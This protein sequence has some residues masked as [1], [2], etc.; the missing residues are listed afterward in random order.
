MHM[1]R[2]TKAPHAPELKI[3][4]TRRST[5]QPITAAELN[6]ALLELPSVTSPGDDKI[7]CEGLKQLGR[8][9]RRGILRLLNYIWRTGQVPATWRQGIIVP[10]L[11]P[12]EPPNS[13]AS[14][15]PV[16]LTST[17]CKL[18]ERIVARRVRD[19][20]EEKLQPQQ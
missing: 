2:P 12:N 8:V 15:R 1:G 14:F 18:M 3:P 7:H 17:L 16:T 4:S 9:S 19:C 6:V 20:I 5:F 11:K 13:M 10:L